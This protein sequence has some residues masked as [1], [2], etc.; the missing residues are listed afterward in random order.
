M[1]DLKAGTALARPYRAAGSL[2]SVDGESTDTPVR[3][4]PSVA[5]TRRVLPTHSGI[6]L[7]RPAFPEQD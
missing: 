4:K 1:E 3:G 6:C 2:S 7:Q 5:G